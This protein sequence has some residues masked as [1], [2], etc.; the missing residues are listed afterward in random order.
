MTNSRCAGAVISYT[1]T[2]ATQC[3]KHRAIK[4]FCAQDG[5]LFCQQKSSVAFG[6]L[7]LLTRMLPLQFQVDYH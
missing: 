3:R 1:C 7:T 2:V 5:S 6:A 4:S